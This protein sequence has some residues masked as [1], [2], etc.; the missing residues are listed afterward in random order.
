MHN[1]N[2]KNKNC[3]LLMRNYQNMVHYFITGHY[4]PIK[5]PENLTLLFFSLMISEGLLE[6]S[7]RWKTNGN[8]IKTFSQ[9]NSV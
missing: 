4:L 1:N 3:C 6:V 2:S 8:S 5:L 7:Y 9:V